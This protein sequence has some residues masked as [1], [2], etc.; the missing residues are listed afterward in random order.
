MTATHDLRNTRWTYEHL[1]LVAQTAM[2]VDAAKTLAKALGRSYEAVR[3]VQ[4]LLITNEEDRQ[5]DSTFNTA[6][7]ELVTQVQ[8]D[9]GIM[10]AK[11]VANQ[12]AA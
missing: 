2:T 8:R 1:M 10:T 6:A 4:R 12:A 7:N 9:A 11:S 5:N 3:I